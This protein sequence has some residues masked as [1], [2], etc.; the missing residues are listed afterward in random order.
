MFELGA[1]LGGAPCAIAA[2][3]KARQAAPARAAV[4]KLPA[5]PRIEVLRRD[6]RLAEASR[7]IRIRP[8]ATRAA[9]KYI[10]ASAMLPARRPAAIAARAQ[11]GIML[12][13]S[14]SGRRSML[15][16]MTGEPAHRQ[17][18]ALAT[19]LAVTCAIAWSGPANAADS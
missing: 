3:L 18:A 11:L 12:P 13:V 15:N 1:K 19:S 14:A 10:R 17:L 16:L 9:G 7:I 4:A 6:K 5:C 8:A 2:M